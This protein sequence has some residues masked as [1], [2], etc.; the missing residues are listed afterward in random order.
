VGCGEEIPLSGEAEHEDEGH[1]EQ[2]VQRAVSVS[3]SHV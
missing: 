1:I 2:V 3:C